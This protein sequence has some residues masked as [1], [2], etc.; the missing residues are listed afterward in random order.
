MSVDVRN[1]DGTRAFAFDNIVVPSHWSGL[2][3]DILVRKY[4]RKSGVPAAA[5]AIPELGVPD[6]LWRSEPD[7]AV[8][9]GMPEE[10]RFGAERDAR[11][12]FHRLAGFWTYWGWKGG[13]F[14]SEEDAR[15]FYDEMQRMLVLQ[16]F[17]PNS[18]QWFNAGLH[19]AYG[20]DQG[21]EGYATADAQSGKTDD[22]PLAYERAFI[23]SCFIQSIKDDLVADEGVI[24]LISNEAKIAKFGAGTGANFSSLRG[25]SEKLS[26][27]GTSSGLLAALKA[28]DRA[29][30]L[31][32]AKGST[33][34]PSKM[35]IVDA[36]H[37]DIF[38]YIDW[39]VEEERKVAALV[40]GSRVCNRY[41]E[42]IFNACGECKTQQSLAV[43]IRNNPRLRRAIEDARD[44]NVPD[45]AILGT[46]ELADHGGS[47][48]PHDEYDA[49]W[50]SDA[51][52]SV[53]GQRSNNSIRLSE[54]FLS[55]V[56]ADGNWDLINRTNNKVARTV[57]A[58]DLWNKIGAAAWA[59]A[60]PG[61]Q[62]ET[63]I[64]EWHTCPQ[65]GRINGSNSCSEFLFLDDTATTLACIN[66]RAVSDSGL[67]MDLAA[68][69]QA[70]RLITLMLEISVS[71]ALYPSHAMAEKTDA[72][73]PLGIG[74]TN[75]G[76]LL[77]ASGVPY[78][79]D[80]GRIFCGAVTA[81]MTGLTYATSA[82]IA[83]DIGP[84]RGFAEN[85]DP[86]LRV[87]RNHRRAAHCHR[88]G[89]EGL[90]RF[91]VVLDGPGGMHQSLIDAARNAWDRALSL[92]EKH[93]Y[94][95]AQ[96]SV[97]APTGTTSLI[98]DCETMGIEP[99]YALVKHKTLAGGGHVVI[100]NRCVPEAL[101]AL[102]YSED[103]IEEIDR[104]VVGART[105]RSAPHINPDTLKARG[106]TD[107]LIKAAESAVATAS[108]LEA[109]FA[110]PILGLAFCARAVGLSEAK[111]MQP[112]FNLLSH[113]GFS[114]AEIRTA[115]AHCF[116][117]GTLEGAPGLNPRHLPVFD[118]SVP[119]GANGNRSLSMTS[120]LRMMAAAQPF[121][122]GAIS[123]TVNVPSRTSLA[124]CQDTFATGAALA[125]KA[126]AIYRDGSKLSQPLTSAN[127]LSSG[128]LDAQPCDAQ[129]DS[130]DIQK[131]AQRI[132]ASWLTGQTRRNGDAQTRVDRI[133]NT[134]SLAVLPDLERVEDAGSDGTAKYDDAT[135]ALVDVLVS[136]IAV[137]MRHGASS[138]DF[139][140]AFGIGITNPV[141]MQNAE[142][143]RE[144]DVGS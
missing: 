107:Q 4:F 130:D 40:S 33:R 99:D 134:P 75:L 29:A 76:G 143:E 135:Q 89:Y 23:H 82:E 138:A 112:G 1:A 126:V 12:V 59:S 17:A 67:E 114:A 34:Q 123:K 133:I 80:E 62:F 68:F 49:G 140:G 43:R 20:I 139:E 102:D 19:W 48:M 66:L 113:L 64:N 52:H 27:G 91:P 55:A 45:N 16:V 26:S 127:T 97:I 41:L 111:L 137:G 57:K 131:V 115:N 70:V 125:L 22:A 9:N 121:V 116:G 84:F 18:P 61:V 2:A 44:H 81:L 50:D 136:S 60:D 14:D 98:L 3:T 96:A 100:I 74:F 30:H 10:N 25:A 56:E 47:W 103:E 7:H 101:R 46:I 15:A 77:M 63:T 21:G 94:R 110:P 118:C 119:C 109:A 6:W 122:S 53:S 24:G 90:S 58:R 93:G 141:L 78:D 128:A 129:S 38:D 104:Y 106:L 120:H 144:R 108:C 37:P 51:Y 87:I 86:M 54:E 39:K 83:A 11:Q 13:Y 65:S 8:L 71:A 142:D 85:R 28:S 5:R 42:E 132:V 105:L 95:N 92:G 124:A 32:T 35:V 88:D 73:R 36:D 31:V 117:H 72:Y 79:S 69:E